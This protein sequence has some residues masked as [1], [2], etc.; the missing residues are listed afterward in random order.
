MAK[1]RT[2]AQAEQLF[3]GDE[4]KW[5]SPKTTIHNA[6]SWYSNQYGPKESK[7]Y[8]ISYLKK[9]KSPKDIIDKISDAPERYFS[10]LGF[11]C[12]MMLM[13]API[14]KEEYI[15][16]KIK[17]IINISS[18][19]AVVSQFAKK[20]DITPVATIQD[21]MFEQATQYIN[22]IEG[23]VDE[24]IKT[25]KSKFKCYDWLVSNAIKQLYIK[26]IIDH[27][28]PLLEELQLTIKKSDEQLVESYSHWSKKELTSY[29]DFINGIIKDCE[30]Y[31]NN[32]KTVRKTRK[33]KAVP[34]DKKVAKLQYKKE[35]VEF[36]LASVNP[37]DIIG[38]KQ[39][40][41][42]NTK[43]KKLG[44][45]N[46]K[47]DSGFGVKGTTIEG[48]DESL[49]IQKTLRKPLDILP[50]VTKG[51]KV[52]LRKLMGSI[53]SKESPLTGRINSDT[54]LMKIIK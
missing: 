18:S 29:F 13:G 32:T 39:V 7:S 34:A 17:E 36:K 51:K 3:I 30:N 52:E 44:V 31:S 8:T 21:R 11:V 9:L 33:K 20:E 54:I 6:L 40:W 16:S 26:Q 48:F 43:Y 46:S 22:D 1:V 14:G 41:V 42:F 53:N 38:A 12:R 19:P 28:S 37:V 45:Y 47:D 4:P 25:K 15:D 2:S 27:Y 35:D 10:N 24:F 50:Q 23:Y 5:D 49:S